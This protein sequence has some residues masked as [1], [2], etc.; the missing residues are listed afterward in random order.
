MGARSVHAHTAPRGIDRAAREAP[1]IGPSPL[2]FV[3]DKTQALPTLPL[4]FCFDLVSSFQSPCHLLPNYCNSQSTALYVSSLQWLPCV[5]QGWVQL[6]ELG[7]QDHW[8]S[9]PC[10]YLQPYFLLFSTYFQNSIITMN[11]WTPS[12]F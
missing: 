10:S 1:S 5:V 6:L 12:T 3:S 11:F 2:W 8:W 7:V 4:P 9:R